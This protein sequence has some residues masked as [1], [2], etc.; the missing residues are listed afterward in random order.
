MKEMK[1]R[2]YV[3]TPNIAMTCRTNHLYLHLEVFLR[4]FTCKSQASAHSEAE[5]QAPTHSETEPQDLP[6][7]Q[8]I[9]KNKSEV[10][11][12]ALN[13]KRV[14]K[15]TILYSSSCEHPVSAVPAQSH[16]GQVE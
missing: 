1:P 4:P 15:Y 7:P 3:N 11:T 13:T 8:E 16:S 5:P 14:A 9:A 6:A 12:A 10:F 2:R